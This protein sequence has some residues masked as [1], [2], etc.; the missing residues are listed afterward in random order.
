[1]TASPYAS[2]AK[3]AEAC[4]AI[5]AD[6]IGQTEQTLLQQLVIAAAVGGGGSTPTYSA[7]ITAFLG[8]AN[9]TAAKESLS[10]AEVQPFIISFKNVTVLTTGTPADVAS[11]ALPAWCT[12]YRL[13][14]IGHVVVAESAAGT[15]AGAIYNVTDAAGGVG[16]TICG[17]FTGPA[18]TS[19]VVLPANTGTAVVPSTVSTIYLRQTANSANAGTL[20]VYLTVVPLL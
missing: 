11:V 15:L 16:V 8:S 17:T 2:D 1:M 10:L 9:D 6:L 3:I 4:A 7:D 20:S 5:G 19:A 13:A 18:S 12:R 14:N